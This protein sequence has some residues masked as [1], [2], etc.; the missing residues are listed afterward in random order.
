MDACTHKR[1]K[2][3][4]AVALSECFAGCGRAPCGFKRRRRHAQGG[5]QTSVLLWRPRFRES[6][7]NHR[8]IPFPT[9]RTRI[10]ETF[11]FER[12]HANIHVNDF[13][14][15]TV[16]LRLLKSNFDVHKVLRGWDGFYHELETLEIDVQ[17]YEVTAFRGDVFAG[18][19]AGDIY[20]DLQ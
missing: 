2:R 3:G 16:E 6:N 11:R 14:I 10:I 9:N 12:K 8:S 4:D 15:A 7:S 17:S 13:R 1:Y 18:L 20:T 19:G 5:L